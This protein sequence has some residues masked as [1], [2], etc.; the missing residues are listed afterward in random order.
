M[1]KFPSTLSMLSIALG[2]CTVTA[3]HAQ[4]PPMNCTPE[5]IIEVCTPVDSVAPANA[6]E[7]VVAPSPKVTYKNGLL[8]ISAENISL[9]EVLREVS[10]KTGAAIEIPGGAAEPVFANIG[11]G[12]VRDVLAAL[13]NGSQFNYV[14][15]GSANTASDLKSVTLTPARPSTEVAS[16]P[17]SGGENAQPVSYQPTFQSGIPARRPA[18]D[19]SEE[20]Q[21][22]AAE[23]ER[24][25]EE[26]MQ[27]LTRE[28]EEEMKQGSPQAATPDSQ[29]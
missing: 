19:Q 29:N 15:A 7:P 3:L 10:S 17:A 26:A 2:L 14:I 5:G 11:P 8:A 25:R 1:A 13:L 12:P 6:V 27:Q 20:Q 23:V 24:A 22:K 16:G 21:A 28:H 18:V 4:N 9:K